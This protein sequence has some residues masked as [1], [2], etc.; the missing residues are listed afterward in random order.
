MKPRKAELES[1]VALLDT[2]SDDVESLARDVLTLAW[3]LAGARSRVGMVIDQPG[4]GV[5][6]HG[7][8]D[9]H[10]QASRFLRGFPF[11][12][13]HRPRVLVQT[14]TTDSDTTEG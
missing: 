10:A 4:V 14:M 11:A 7:P 6:L 8:F 13:P 1:M 9:S 5:T 3:S 12:G 2:P